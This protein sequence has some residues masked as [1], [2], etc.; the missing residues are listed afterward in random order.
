LLSVTGEGDLERAGKV[1]FGGVVKEVS[2]AYL[3]EAK[4]GDYVIV[5]VGF[6]LSVVDEAEA[7]AV[8]AYLQQM[9][10]LTELNPEAPPPEPPPP[11][12]TD[13]AGV[14][15]RRSSGGYDPGSP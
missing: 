3:P 1:S 12:A 4:V 13:R 5:H 15:P 2:L 7:Q 6:A 10:E 11:A 14:N 8:F 9:D